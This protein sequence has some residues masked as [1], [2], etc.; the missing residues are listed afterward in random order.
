MIRNN[1]SKIIVVFL[2]IAAGMFS[3]SSASACEIEWSV[4]KG[5]KKSYQP[6]D[7]LVIQVNVFLTH[8]NCPESLKKTD[9]KTDGIK[10]KQATKWSE[11]SAGTWVRKFKVTIEDNGKGEVQISATRT[12]DKEGGFGVLKLT[13]G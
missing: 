12:C 8:R 11:K 2:V 6:G 4:I 1:F 3:Y 5:Q 10:I 7:E 13:T 9:L